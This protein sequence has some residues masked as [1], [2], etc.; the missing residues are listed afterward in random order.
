M[1]R[2]KLGRIG[3]LACTAKRDVYGWRPGSRQG[4]GGDP[5]TPRLRRGRRLFAQQGIQVRHSH[6]PAFQ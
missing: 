2:R 4:T 1:D 6:I 5:P 3:V